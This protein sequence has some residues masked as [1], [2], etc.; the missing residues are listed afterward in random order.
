[1]T[2]GVS[3]ATFHALDDAI[4]DAWTGRIGFTLPKHAFVVGH[5]AGKGVA[6]AFG[7]SIRRCPEL[8]CIAQ[9]IEHVAD[10]CHVAEADVNVGQH[11]SSLAPRRMVLSLDHPSKRIS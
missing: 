1:M 3:W 9:A 11:T 7:Q 4:E 5:N 10:G 8:G 2:E 6:V